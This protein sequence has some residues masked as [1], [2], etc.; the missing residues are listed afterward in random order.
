MP[1]S[2]TGRAYENVCDSMKLRAYT[3]R[4]HVASAGTRFQPDGLPGNL[5]KR[6]A[7]LVRRVTEAKDR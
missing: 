6:K 3:R 7:R 4:V 5:I 1:A 2:A